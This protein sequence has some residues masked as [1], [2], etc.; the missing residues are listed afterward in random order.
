LNRI[1]TY[2]LIFSL[3]FAV[4]ALNSAFS[5]SKDNEKQKAEIIWE[6]PKYLKWSGGEEDIEVGV[7]GG[8]KALMKELSR[9][10]KKRYPYGKSF[11][12][13]FIL[14]PDVVAEFNVQLLYVSHEYAS[15]Y[16]EITKK[17][18]PNHTILITESWL[19]KKSLMINFSEDD[20]GFVEQINAR[21]ITE[22]GVTISPKIKADNVEV[23][24]DRYLL[25]E[26]EDNLRKEKQKVKEQQDKLDMVEKDLEYKQKKLD[27]QKSEIDAS[28]KKIAEQKAEVSSLIGQADVQRKELES[29]NLVLAQKEKDI[30]IQNQKLTEQQLNVKEQTDKLEKLNK[31][32]SE[33]QDRINEQRFTMLQQTATIKFQK[34]ALTIFIGFFVI[35]LTLVFFILRGYRI[36]RKQNKLLALQKEEIQQQAGQLEIINK[37]LEKLSIVASETSSAVV[38]LDTAG[39]FEW[40]NAGFT[41]M[42]GFTL[43]LLRNEVGENIITASNHPQIKEFVEN[44][45]NEKKPVIYETYVTS[46]TGEKKWSQTTLSPTLNAE[47]QVTKLVLIDSDITKIK[48]AEN[49]ILIQNEK[50]MAQAR[51][52]ELNNFE[53][54]KL[55]IVASKTENSV[56]IAQPDG[57][58]E[59]VNEGF[60]R[61]LGLTFDEF[62]QK[63]SSNMFDSSLIENLRERVE[64]AV[65]ERKSIIYSAK[66]I[67]AD[68]RQIWIQTTLTP[69]LATDGS[70]RKIIAIDADVTMIKLAEEQIALQNKKI[71]DSII[72]AQR[73]Q[74]AVLPPQEIITEY[75][76]ENFILFKPR[77][78]VSGDFYWAARKGEKLVVTAAD[79]TGHGVPGAFM[80]LLGI[81]FLNEIMA[82]FDENEIS[83]DLIL[84]ELRKKV[85]T[86]LRQMG[87]DGEA[88]DGM[89]MAL[90]VIDKGKGIV[91]FSGAENPLVIIRN[92]EII[93]IKADLMPIGIS[94]EEK[95]FRK[96]V[97]PIFKNDWLYM[98]SDGY[99]DQFCEVDKKKFFSKRL[100][101]YLQNISSETP[102]KQAEM[103]N[104]NFENW[105]GSL[106]QMDDVL[107]MGIKIS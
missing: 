19:V 64:N 3:I 36:T 20:N 48:E 105:R 27:R 42:Y 76:P 83:S 49:E 93:D 55:S 1:S 40:V 75:L 24:D 86:S 99:A 29:K 90:C 89:D 22:A 9:L 4:F 107:V 95:P 18:R 78:I 68:G 30:E 81:S 33:N 37:E 12:I 44:C 104:T 17:I 7:L 52:L 65:T 71:T 53:L 39:N 34:N 14:N 88:K 60:T 45:I 74:N 70:L 8:S 57:E 25:N 56:V 87:K 13:V 46:R 100:K 102:E 84:N 69:I 35:I 2:K 66:T 101:Q 21:N 91:E 28:E 85:K 5:Q 47:G 98:F 50:I 26:S 97:V 103:L 106:R 79:C 80:S 6:L 23:I 41:R 32:V 94:Y 58:I 92:N 15:S 10:E 62:K 73:I 67:T 31:E 72:Y 61:L 43:Q 59:W 11:K 82:L 96:E 16:D 54:E 63:Y 38:I 51:E 77:D